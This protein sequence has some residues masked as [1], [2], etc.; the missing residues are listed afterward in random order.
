MELKLINYSGQNLIL[1]KSE[2]EYNVPYIK[3]S[4]SCC[5]GALQE[6][7]KLQIKDITSNN[8]IEQKINTLLIRIKNAVQPELEYLDFLLVDE[9]T[10]MNN[11]RH[12][13]KFLYILAICEIQ[14]EKVTICVDK[15]NLQK[16]YSSIIDQ[17][18]IVTT[19]T[20]YL[21]CDTGFTCDNLDETGSNICQNKVG[22][23][24]KLIKSK[25]SNSVNYGNDQILSEGQVRNN[26][27][28]H[29]YINM[30]PLNYSKTDD[31]SESYKMGFE[32]GSNKTFNNW[33]WV[34]L[35]V[36]II[37]FGVVIVGII[38]SYMYQYKVSKDNTAILA[39]AEKQ[40][41]I[42]AEKNPPQY[43]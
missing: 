11:L 32:S 18:Q 19:N 33:M 14:N 24:S 37:I 39:S 4:I 17:P 34:I 15:I 2:K 42:Y 20:L 5:I 21:G 7:S 23:F 3:E 29:H 26:V 16:K 13:P 30:N 10:Y 8:S 1:F 36:F 43:I 31:I 27:Y 40:A 38:I 12:M 41:E 6:L 35:V 28:M 9:A 22:E 25:Y